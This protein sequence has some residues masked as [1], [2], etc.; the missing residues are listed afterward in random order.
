MNGRANSGWP[1]ASEATVNR[2]SASSVMN[3]L[4]YQPLRRQ[5]SLKNP[6]VTRNPLISP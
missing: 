3:P 4:P 2:S 1:V 5:S 6:P